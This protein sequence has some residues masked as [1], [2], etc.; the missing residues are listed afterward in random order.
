[1]ELD[2]QVKWPMKRSGEINLHIVIV[3]E[4]LCI[5]FHQHL[6]KDSEVM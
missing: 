2:P 5:K 1:M 6:L 3:V 4:V